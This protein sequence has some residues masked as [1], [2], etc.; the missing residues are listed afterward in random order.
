MA[1]NVP[2]EA[3]RMLIELGTLPD[4]ETAT[5]VLVFDALKP[6]EAIN[7]QHWSEWGRIANTLS[8]QQLI[9]LI[10]GLTVAEEVVLG[11]GGSISGIIWTFRNLAA[12]DYE[13]SRVLADWILAR[14]HNP[15]APFG[16]Q[17]F[18]ARSMSEYEQSASRHA[19]LIREGLARDEAV[20]KRSAVER[21]IFKKQ[22]V[23]AAQ[24]RR[25]S[26]RRSFLLELANLPLVKQL[27]RLAHDEHRP[28]EWYPT[29]M[30]HLAT[31]QVVQEM[32]E[33]LMLAFL[34][35]LKGKHR[36]PW[37]ALKKRMRRSFFEQRGWHGMPW[38]RKGWF[39]E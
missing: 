11:N 30:A 31:D 36:G 8:T 20:E 37:A 21:E 35:K 24:E 3:V 33:E 5:S 22:K 32:T 14:S 13:E 15:Y 23:R 1:E 10:R 39:G 6:F 27:E 34:Y 9:A 19:R 7:R 28:V 29:R 4:S 2:L 38:D 17:N 12:R 25:S 16:T 26:E 18:G